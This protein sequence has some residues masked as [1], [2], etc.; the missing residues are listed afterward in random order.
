METMTLTA[1][2][3]QH[4]NPQGLTHVGL[5]YHRLDEYVA[6][7]IPAVRHALAHGA[8]VLIAVPGDRHAAMRDELGA[9]AG[10][11]QFVDM[12][13][14]GRNP[15]WI[16]PGVLLDFAANHAETP[17]YAIGEPIWS[18]R[19]PAEY[20][21][22]VTHEAL[23]NVALADRDA[24]I[25]CPYDATSLSA[26][27]I[28]DAYSTHPSMTSSGSSETSNNY[29]DPL[30]VVG[31]FNEPLPA[32]PEHAA[33]MDYG[34]VHDLPALRRF[35]TGEATAAELPRDRIGDLALAITELG[36]NTVEHTDGPGSV[37]VWA[38]PDA[39]ICQ[40]SDTG[41]L[42]DPMAGRRMPSATASRGR[43]LALVNSVSG[44]VRVHTSPQ[45]TTFRVH[46]YR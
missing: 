27:V 1:P 45:G 5:L 35:V 13:V 32:P 25:V 22:C 38:E 14:V 4:T 26:D 12:T 23:I 21:A 28:E 31:R 8:A 36:T 42:S 17:V 44:L 40:L 6:A 34:R 10:S 18:S 30:V 7:T 33:S 37:A 16:L 2:R 46:M 3:P 9:D 11:V 19:T 41:H 24:T 15:G 43:G 39:V 29:T 20:P